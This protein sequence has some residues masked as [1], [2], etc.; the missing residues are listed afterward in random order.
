MPD[1][2]REPVKYQN[3]ILQKKS[4]RN[5]IPPRSSPTPDADVATSSRH[6]M[7]VCCM[8]ASIDSNLPL[9]SFCQAQKMI[10]VS[11]FNSPGRYRPTGSGDSIMAASSR[12]HLIKSLSPVCWPLSPEPTA[13]KQAQRTRLQP[14]PHKYRCKRSQRQ[15][16]AETYSN[17][18]SLTMKIFAVHQK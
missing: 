9:P 2:T 4:I 17:P 12:L 5:E 3:K 7:F 10:V 16:G 15:K 1:P 8:S 18:H 6:P 13:L 14:R 11:P